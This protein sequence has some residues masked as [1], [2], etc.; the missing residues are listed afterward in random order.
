MAKGKNATQAP[1]EEAT[2]AVAPSVAPLPA[3]QAPRRPAVYRRMEGDPDSRFAGLWIE[4]QSNLLN[5]EVRVLGSLTYWADIH[6]LL[7]QYIRAW[8]IQGPR[9]VVVTRP[10]V[11]SEDGTAELVPERQVTELVWETLPS[12]MEAGPVVFESIDQ[13]TKQWIWT[14]AQNAP[15]RRDDAEG[16]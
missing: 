3:V 6:P 10:A 2:P 16:K 11:M 15:Y 1:D 7:C 12:P 8:N 14:Q 13:L 4:T 5:V 9:E